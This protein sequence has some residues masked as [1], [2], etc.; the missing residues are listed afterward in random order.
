MSPPTIAEARPEIVSD[1]LPRRRPAWVE[2]A[3]SAD[4]KTV[5]MLFGGGAL[6]LFLLLT[7]ISG[8]RSETLSRLLRSCACSSGRGSCRT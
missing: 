7:P 4:H 2:R 5:A 1:G 3:T 6:A 8:P